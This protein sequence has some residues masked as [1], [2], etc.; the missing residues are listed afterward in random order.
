MKIYFIDE[1][2]LE[3]VDGRSVDIRFGI[4]NYFP[5]DFDSRVA[6]KSINVGIVGS[7][8]TIEGTIN[9]LEKCRNE[10]PAK[11]SNQPNL[12]PKFPGF[13]TDTA[14]KSELVFDSSLQRVIP[15]KQ[16]DMAIS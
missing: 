4:A 5:V 1:P 15:Q 3:F 9:W 12:F 6:P 2:E 11:K 8:E 7:N 10:I 14:F 13:R 16:L